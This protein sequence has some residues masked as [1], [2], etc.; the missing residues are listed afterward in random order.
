MWR[1][2]RT[3][4]AMPDRGTRQKKMRQCRAFRVETL[5]ERAVLS[6]DGVSADHLLCEPIVP[7]CASA[8]IGLAIGG[9]DAAAAAGGIVQGT[10]AT[11]GGVK[12]LDRNA[13]GIRDRGPVVGDEPDVVFVV[14]ISG[15]TTGPFQGTSV[16]DV[17]GDGLSNTILDAE[18]AGFIALNEQLVQLGLGSIARVSVV[19]FDSIGEIRDMD[20]VANGLQ[21]AAS[22]STDADANGVR[23][24]DQILRSLR[25]RGLTN[26]EDAL[27]KA[28][29][30]LTALGTL[31]GDGNVILLSDGFPTAGGSHADEAA[32]LRASA[33]NV[34]AFGVGNGASLAALQIIDPT[35]TIFTR[36][37]ELLA[38]FSGVGGGSQTFLEPGMAGITVYLDLNNN[39]QLDVGE[40]TAVTIEDDP[41][42]PDVDELGMFT[43]TNLAPGTYVVREI[44]PPGHRQTRPAGPDFSFQITVA[45]GQSVTDLEIGNAMSTDT[46]SISGIVYLDVNN[47]GVKDPSELPLPNVPVRLEGPTTISVV[48]D[49]NGRYRFDN[50]S[51]GT[52]TVTET[53]PSAFLDGIDTQG[54]PLTGRAENDRF[55][56]LNIV[57]GEALTDYNF[58]ERGLRPELITKRLYMSDS[59]PVTQ[60]IGQLQLGPTNGSVTFAAHSAA[61]IVANVP[62]QGPAL[63]WEL[64]DSQLLPLAIKPDSHSFSMSV[65]PGHTYL[66]KVVVSDAVVVTL[67]TL[68]QNPQDSQPPL[69]SEP[70]AGAE[71][72]DQ[73]PTAR[74]VRIHDAPLRRVS[75]ELFVQ[76]RLHTDN[77]SLLQ[78]PRRYA[79]ERRVG[80]IFGGLRIDT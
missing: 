4:L 8:A 60:L 44:V 49:A 57:G 45:A 31:P 18:I 76:R 5:E 65:E 42:T 20:P 72:K 23:D 67:T 28:Q 1:R 14:D 21:F 13:N 10:G 32:A 58:G 36:S 16:G 15:S 2:L 3:W 55:V 56:D 64:Y 6:G 19:T 47:N 46:S 48:T 69:D 39:S 50:L 7:D 54:Q 71:A 35:A 37:D 78:M 38:V 61:S 70:H 27:A 53:Q 79:V 62:A 34:R 22:P 9:P 33:I 11:I 68:A 52:Y 43:F 26:F 66:L 25:D 77:R 29:Q 63:S 17:N 59:P 80:V 75:R 73:L 12:F 41:A 40:P 74:R 51:A 30:V 24:V